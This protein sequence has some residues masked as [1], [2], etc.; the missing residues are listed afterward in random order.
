MVKIKKLLPHLCIILAGMF[1]TFYIIDQFNGAMSVLGSN[2][3][4]KLLLFVFC[5]IA[6]VVSGILISKQRRE[7]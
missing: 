1:I 3:L 2:A 4:A 5:I 7:N 6:I